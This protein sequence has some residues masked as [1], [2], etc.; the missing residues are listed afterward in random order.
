FQQ[1][2]RDNNGYVDE[3]EAARSGLRNV[4]KMM[5]RDG[6]GKVYEK[7]MLAWLDTVEDL[8]ARATAACASLTFTDGGKGLWELF[9][10][11]RDGRLGLREIAALPKLV[12]EL[13]RNGD[14]ALG[15][16][17]IPHSYLFKLEQGTGGGGANPYAV[18]DALGVQTGPR[19]LTGRGPLWFQK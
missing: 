9:D 12:D 11:D 5:D 13:D 6:D 14:G 15:P 10:T 17:E 16:D 1:A 19:P 18:L 3:K 2:D 4:F 7:E 8:Q